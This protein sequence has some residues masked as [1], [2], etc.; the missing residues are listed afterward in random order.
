ML[1]TLGATSLKFSK[2]SQPVGRSEPDVC[3]LLEEPQNLDMIAGMLRQAGQQARM[4]RE[5]TVSQTR[6]S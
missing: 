4:M 3:A 1:D 2:N 6:T 5:A